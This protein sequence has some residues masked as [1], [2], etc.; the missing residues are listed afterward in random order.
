MNKKVFLTSIFI[1]S[2]LSFFSQKGP[3]KTKADTAK[4]KISNVGPMINTEFPDYGPVI[5]ADAHLMVFT[6]RYPVTDKELQYGKM[7]MEN[8]YQSVYDEKKKR[9][10]QAVRLGKAINIPGRHN[11]V[12]SLSNDGQ[13]M[14]IYRDDELG[15]GD[16]YQ[17]A[18]TGTNWGEPIKLPEP[19]NS[20]FHESSASYSPDGQILYFV[21]NRKTGSLGG[22]DIWMS[23]KSGNEWGPAE[24]LGAVV[25][26]ELDEDR[27]FMHPDG[28]TLYFSSKGHN[29]AGGFDIFKTVFEEGH[30]TKPEALG[31]GINTIED[32]MSFVLA[33]NGVL[34]YYASEKA[35]GLGKK[36]IYEIRIV[37]IKTNKKETSPQLTLLK[38]VIS[39]E[40]TGA[41]IEANI[42]IIDNEKNKVIYTIKSNKATGKYLVSLPSGKNYGIAVRPVGYLFHSENVNIPY[43]AGYQE[44]TKD[45]QLKKIEIGKSIVLNNIFYDFDKSTLRPESQNELDRLIALLKENPT[46]KIELSSHTDDKGTDEYNE[47]LSQERAQS[48]VDFLIN[49][50]IKP[51]RLVAKGYGEK[52]PVA[53]NDTDENRQLNRRT[54]FKI[55]EVK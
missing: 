18:L 50:G 5:S 28:K 7:G 51:E 33:A 6:S 9:W 38:G 26:S 40:I 4:T 22:R 3:K 55:L 17:C 14:I 49:K 31:H 25:N 37:P 30:W 20:E 27:I 11:S 23:R 15:N 42:D 45:I 48:V 43:S 16:L 8:I 21:S 10:N 44:I 12:I 32:D 2:L 24:N 1:F 47:K 36:D 39:D 29:S 46:I 34:G 54:E 53:A 52:V 13:S 41:F 35:G 19:I